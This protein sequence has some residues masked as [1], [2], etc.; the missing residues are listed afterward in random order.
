VGAYDDVNTLTLQG[1]PVPIALSSGCP[2]GAATTTAHFNGTYVL[3]PGVHDA[4]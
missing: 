2:G 4:S 1:A 3:T